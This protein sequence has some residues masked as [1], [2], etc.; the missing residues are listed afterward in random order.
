M[1]AG[2]DWSAEG[3]MRLWD[4]WGAEGG[5]C[6]ATDRKPQINQAKSRS[7]SRKGGKEVGMDP[8]GSTRM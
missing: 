2:L 1:P 7:E 5:I 4:A 8:T 3:P 6:Y